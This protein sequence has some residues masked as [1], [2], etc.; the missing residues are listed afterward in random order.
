M[1]RYD[2][3]FEKDHVF[4][5]ERNGESTDDTGQ[6]VKELSSTIEFMV[7]MDQSEELFIDCFSDHF[8]SW[9]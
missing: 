6:N 7:F 5:S 8:P 1:E 4:I 9:N 2:D 3:V